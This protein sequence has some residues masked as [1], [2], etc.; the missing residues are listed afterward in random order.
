MSQVHLEDYRDLIVLAINSVFVPV[1]IALAF[2]VFLWGVYKYFILGAADEKN[3]A[4]GRT[5]VLYS[6]IG[7]VLIFS[8]WGV[9]NIVMGTLNLSAGTNSPTP[10]TIRIQ[11]TS[12][13][14]Y[15][16]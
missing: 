2:I 9:V 14:L 15:E 10:P 16:G 8:L 3:R 6:V 12:S 5:F 13:S 1:L 11:P 7:F 4:E